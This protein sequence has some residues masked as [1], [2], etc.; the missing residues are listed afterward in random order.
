[1]DF[2]YFILGASAGWV[3]AHLYYKKSSDSQKRELAQLAHQ[4]TPKTKLHD[5]I[6]L[7]NVSSWSQTSLD[8]KIAWIANLD[9]TFQ[10]HQGTE[11]REFSEPWT[12]VFPDQHSS[13]CTISLRINNVSIKE[14]EFVSVDG[15]RIFVPIP[16][17]R[18]KGISE[19][20]REF[21]WSL[22]SLRVQIS[23][24]I[25]SYYIYENLEGVAK[26]AEVLIE[27]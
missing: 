4:L 8:G 10:M 2:L 14:L 6:E 5:F 20:E 9:N 22:S 27:E 23:K 11:Y 12:D 13:A 17:A 18:H 21:Y 16:E 25:G 26:Q 7:L 19:T 24:V 3:I 1:M 15:G